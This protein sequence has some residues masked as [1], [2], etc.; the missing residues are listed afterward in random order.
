LIE[1]VI[2][3][4]LF[5]GYIA[6]L[7]WVPKLRDTYRYHGAEHMVIH[8]YEAGEA[9]TVANA[10]RHPTAHPRCGTEFLALVMIIAVLGFALLG[11]GNIFWLLGTRLALMPV[12]AGVSYET[13]RFLARHRGSAAARALA[14]PGIALQMITTR[15]PDDAMI[16]VAIVSLEVTMTA[17]GAEP[18]AGSH[19]PGTI[20][21]ET[22]IAEGVA[23][24]RSAD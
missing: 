8:T 19:I 17:D 10:R 22:A 18:A 9:L 11:K 1:G 12:I 3:A 21:L 14:M 15:V 5:V 6:L 13:L 4:A 7:G 20:S 24:E 23:A 2:R 16:E